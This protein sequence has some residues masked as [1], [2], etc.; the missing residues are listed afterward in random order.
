MNNS[1]NRGYRPADIDNNL[2][3]Y[4]HPVQIKAR[5]RFLEIC[6]EHGNGKWAFEKLEWEV[7][8]EGIDEYE[9]LSEDEQWQL[10][11]FMIAYRSLYK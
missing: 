2:E 3:L 4:I 1:K 5:K 7:Y 9:A 11:T 6:K 10:N 8:V